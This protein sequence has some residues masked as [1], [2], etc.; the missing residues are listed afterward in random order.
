LGDKFISV[1]M[2][3]PLATSSYL[4]SGINKIG[5]VNK[6][7]TTPAVSQ[8]VIRQQRNLIKFKK[9]KSKTPN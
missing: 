5:S 3:N 1:S 2:R 4:V 9:N 6:S 7:L 8:Y